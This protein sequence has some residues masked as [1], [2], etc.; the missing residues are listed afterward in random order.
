M[1][2]KWEEREICKKEKKAMTKENDFVVMKDIVKECGMV[3][4]RNVRL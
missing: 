2:A 4:E 3:W 1:K